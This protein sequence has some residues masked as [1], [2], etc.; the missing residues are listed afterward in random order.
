MRIRQL[1]FLVVFTLSLAGLTAI[2]AY[3]AG[4]SFDFSSWKLQTT[5]S[6]RITV[7]PKDDVLVLLLPTGSS[8]TSNQVSFTH[9]LPG[10]YRL[11]AESEGYQSVALELDVPS[12]NTILI[13]PLRLW[14]VNLPQ[15]IFVDTE[16]PTNTTIEELPIS[17][18]SAISQLQLEPA[19][20]KFLLVNQRTVVVLDRDTSTV[21][22]LTQAGNVVQSR[23]LGSAQDI[24]PTSDP[25][26][27]LLVGQFELQRVSL[28]SGSTE[29]I[30]RLS[31]PITQATWLG[32]LPYIAYSSAGSIHII[33]VRAIT[34]YNDQLVIE[35]NLPINELWYVAERDEL[36]FI[37]ADK[38]YS[39]PLRATK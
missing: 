28:D 20:L 2:L 29:T 7:E 25:N 9:L 37:S 31:T 22:M 23:S 12:N 8:S 10:K 4:Y 39:Y 15:R 17:L 36:Q 27:L 14:P 16:Q 34:R 19:N 24:Q 6:M 26:D 11:Y 21:T 5:G 35:H 33:D 38:T 13:E 18:Q 3:S 32:S 1:I 30:M